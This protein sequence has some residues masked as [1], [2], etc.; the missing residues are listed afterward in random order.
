MN[1][2]NKLLAINGGTKISEAPIL[3]HKPYLDEADFKIVDRTLRST[4]ISGDGPECREFEKKLAEYLGVKHVLYMN[5][6]TTALEIAFRV[7]DFPQGAEI[8][9]PDFTYTSTAV[10]ALYNN[11]KIVL[12][13]VY[14]DNGSLDVSKLENYITK[15]TVAIAAVDYGGIPAEMDE[16]M[17]I[18]KKHNLYVVHD[19]AQSIGSVYKGKKTGCQGHV[20]TFSFHGTKNLTT[21]EGGALVTNDDVIAER[22]KILRE[23]GTDKYSFLTDNKDRGYYEYVDIGNSYVQSNMNGAM[24]ITQ[25]EKLDWM[26]AERKKIAEYYKKEL[27]EIDGLDFM[28]ITEGADHN[29]HL[30]GILVPSEHRYWI[31]DALRA[32]GVMSN[33]H[34]TPLHRNKYYKDLATDEAMPGS[35]KFFN[36][37]LRLPIYPSLTENERKLVVQAVKKVFS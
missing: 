22:V 36:K 32:E 13:D 17:A 11:L 10:A 26:N 25:L 28:R 2:G 3:I 35:M 5:S 29:W 24:G 20:S 14:S 15:K 16:I 31:M 34:Y 30:F 4:F 6:A 9:C 8:I 19:T 33:V 37:L 18:A 27:S 23:K 1:T 7:K 21:G 12:A